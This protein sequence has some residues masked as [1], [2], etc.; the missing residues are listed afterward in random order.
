MPSQA[1][2]TCQTGGKGKDT[3]RNNG[4][5]HN[6]KSPHMSYHHIYQC[7]W[8]S[9]PCSKNIHII[10]WVNHK[11]TA[12]IDWC[13][14]VTLPSWTRRP[15]TRLLQWNLSSPWEGRPCDTKAY[16]EHTPRPLPIRHS[17]NNSRYK[18]T[19][20]FYLPLPEMASIFGNRIY[21]R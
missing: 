9:P 14:W 18:L 8:G 19:N 12:R 3:S 4:A 21:D 10:M 2:K 5:T 17:R 20:N 7:G 15:P 11:H 6:M 1:D 13:D 16:P